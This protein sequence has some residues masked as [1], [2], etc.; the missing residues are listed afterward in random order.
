MGVSRVPVDLLNPGQVFACLGLMEVTEILSG[1]CEGAFA[2]EHG[3]TRG[4]FALHASGSADPLEDVIRFLE[5]ATVRAVAPAGFG[6]AA[7][8]DGVVT[9]EATDLTYPCPLPDSPSALP[10]ALSAG[11]VTVPLEHWADGSSRD[12][13]KFWAGAGGYSGAA[14]TRDTLRSIERLSPLDRARSRQVPFEV[15]APM[16]SSFR[17]DWRRDYV[18]MDVGF[19]PNS[20]GHVTMV[21]YPFVE[22]LAAVGLQ[23]SR[24]ARN[25]PRDRLRYRYGV[26]TVLL[27]TALARVVLGAHSA[28]FPVRSFSMKLDWPGKEGQARCIVGA[29]EESSD[30]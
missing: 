29:H 3:E 4:E 1:A 10:G 24:P 9:I 20:H 16:S 27:P 28:G 14:L 6:L 8:E 17:F 5:R 19:S 11:D 23:H 26:S 15:E 2:P 7:K 22:L 21:G 30:E 25:A 13:V 18:P 12:N